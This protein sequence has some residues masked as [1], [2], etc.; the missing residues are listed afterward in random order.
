MA[1]KERQIVQ[2]EVVAGVDAEAAARARAPPLACRARR[3]SSTPLGRP[4]RRRA[5]RARCTARRDRRR[6]RAAQSTAS[7]SRIDEQADADAVRAAGGRSTSSSAR[8]GAID[9]PAGLAGDLARRDRHERALVRPHR[10]HQR[11]QIGPR[12]AF[13][14]ELDV[15]RLRLEQRGDLADVAGVM[16]RSSARGCTVMPG[17]PASSTPAP[18]RAR[19]ATLPPRELRSVAT[20]L[21]LT[22]R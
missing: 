1:A 18:P 21:T 3:L 5:R 19:T 22:D 16:C 6:A 12:I 13:D 7:S 15:G 4:A 20:L 11:D 9:R 14:V 10:E 8:P 2:I 17:A